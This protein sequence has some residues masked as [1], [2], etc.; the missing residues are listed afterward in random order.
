VGLSG[1]SGFCLFL[2]SLY[3]GTEE[4]SK[5]RTKLEIQWRV[6][7]IKKDQFDGQWVS[8]MKATELSARGEDLTTYDRALEQRVRR[9]NHNKSYLVLTSC[10]R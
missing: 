8:R 3:G 1:F 4:R 10:C 6:K 2:R 9:V 7:G 5:C